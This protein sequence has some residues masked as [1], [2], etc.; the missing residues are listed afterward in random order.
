MNS[1]TIHPKHYINSGL[2]LMEYLVAI[3]HENNLPTIA[4]ICQFLKVSDRTATRIRVNLAKMGILRKEDGK[5][6]LT[7]KLYK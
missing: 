4:E 2:P 6:F 3:M 5:Y 1:I 7:D